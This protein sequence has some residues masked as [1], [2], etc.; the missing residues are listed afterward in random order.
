VQ[1][2]LRMVEVEVEMDRKRKAQ[3]FP[4]VEVGMDRK[5]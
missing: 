5:P 2:F 1:A 3:T 4:V